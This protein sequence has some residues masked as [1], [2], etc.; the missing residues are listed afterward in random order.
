MGCGMWDVAD[1]SLESGYDRAQDELLLT[2]YLLRQPNE[3]DW[4]R[5][6]ANKVYV[7]YLWTLWGKARVPY[8]GE[9]M[10]QHALERYLRMKE[11][12]A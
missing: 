6:K 7:D 10:E 1:V 8:E 5:F 12:M 11:N 3:T 2:E 9:K 4:K